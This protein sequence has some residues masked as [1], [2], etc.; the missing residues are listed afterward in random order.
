MERK[1]RVY[2]RLKT[3]ARA[4]GFN[5][6]QLMGVAADIADKLE[7]DENAPEEELDAEIDKAIDAVIPSLKL[8]QSLADSQMEEW[9]RKNETTE[10]DEDDDDAQDDDAASRKSGQRGKSKT[11]SGEGDDGIPEWAKGLM[12]SIKTLSEDVVS[13]KSD[14]IATSRRTRLEE[15][16]KDSGTFGSSKLKDFARMNFKDDDDFE[17]F[18]EEVKEDVKT[19][20]KENP[21][22]GK[23]GMTI[24]PF[25]VSGGKGNEDEVL[26]EDDIKALV[27]GDPVSK[28]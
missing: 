15:L 27:P 24:P 7:A 28:D 17:E 9:R 5:R 13:I 21:K 2:L 14:K 4:F 20:D 26:S 16:V 23:G 3:K 12:E 22:G 8:A 10:A 19:Y 6:K 18:L 11:K 1:Q 25:N